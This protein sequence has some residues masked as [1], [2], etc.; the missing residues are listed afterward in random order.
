MAGAHRL[1]HLVDSSE[2]MEAF[3][4]R[5]RVPNDVRLRYCSVNNIPVLN[6][7]EILISVIGIVEGG[8]RFPLNPLLIDFLQTVNACPAQVS[9]NVLRIVMVVAT[10]NRLLGVRLS[11]KEI[12]HV[13]S[14]TC[15]GFESATSCHLRAKKVDVKLV[16][17]LPKSHKGFDNDFFVVSG[18][19]FTGGS[20]CRSD[21]GCP[22]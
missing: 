15:P 5:Y 22:G 16:N 7:D 21:F 1:A 10:L 4:E 3:R 17:G 20:T 2:G 19:L 14:Y 13:Y 12:L 6:Q 9:I 18:N 11:P 8:V